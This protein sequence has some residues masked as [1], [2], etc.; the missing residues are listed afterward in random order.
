[1]SNTYFPTWGKAPEIEYPE[2]LRRKASVAKQSGF[3]ITDDDINPMLKPHQRDSSAV[4]MAAAVSDRPPSGPVFASSR[5]I[6]GDD[7]PE[8][9]ARSFCDQRSKA[10][11]AFTCSID[12]FGIDT[13]VFPMLI[14]LAS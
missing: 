1:M 6:V 2:F 8:A 11:A 7:T 12:T 14:L 10:R 13:D 4:R 5:L 3:A 9:S